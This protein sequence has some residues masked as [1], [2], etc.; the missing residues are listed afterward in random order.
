MCKYAGQPGCR[1]DSSLSQGSESRSDDESSR[2]HISGGTA[3][4]AEECSP[5]PAAEQILHSLSTLDDLP[6]QGLH[7]PSDV[8]G[9]SSSGYPPQPLPDVTPAVDEPV[10][11]DCARHQDI[12]SGGLPPQGQVEAL[13]HT[14][15][16]SRKAASWGRSQQQRP[17]HGKPQQRQQLD[18]AAQALPFGGF[19]GLQHMSPR[20][21]TQSQTWSPHTQLQSQPQQQG[22]SAWADEAKQSSQNPAE[23]ADATRAHVG[24]MQFSPRKEHAADQS[25][26]HTLV[27]KLEVPAQRASITQLQ[28]YLLEGLNSGQQMGLPDETDTPQHH[29]GLVVPNGHQNAS[30][31]AE[32]CEPSDNEQHEEVAGHADGI[33]FSI[34]QQEQQLPQQEPDAEQAHPAVGLNQ[35]R[36]VPVHSVEVSSKPQHEDLQQ[37]C[38]PLLDPS[39]LLAPKLGAC[40]PVPIPAQHGSRSS[41]RTMMQ[42]SVA[43]APTSPRQHQ[44]PTEDSQADTAQPS[45][46]GPSAGKAPADGQR[47]DGLPGKLRPSADWYQQQQQQSTSQAATC[48]LTRGDAQQQQQCSASAPPS[49]AAA[50]C[51]VELDP[52]QGSETCC[53]QDLPADGTDTSQQQILQSF[54]R[55]AC[56][57]GYLS[58]SLA[59]E[60]SDGMQHISE[61][62]K[63]L[64]HQLARMQQLL[65][66]YLGAWDLSGR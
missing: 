1:P 29:V 59:L 65:N 54:P 3:Q 56:P 64:T 33:L 35:A 15:E 7:E 62:I 52:V 22:P 31:S 39:I 34:R 32:P 49:T 2:Q 10:M 60:L 66:P 51:S 11:R 41:V 46:L 6:V 20:L 12:L 14:L 8:A 30:Q 23:V 63:A 4:A 26:S 25:I 19:D 40:V 48:M 57:S 38:L 61:S 21:P 43:N 5:R 13:V 42:P 27:H 18:S 47:Q 28:P 9:V 16:S 24:S 45:T 55:P 58:P 36:E 37:Q 17:Q 44:C 53:K 50:A